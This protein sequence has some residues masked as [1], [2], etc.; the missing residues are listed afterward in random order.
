MIMHVSNF[1]SQ[2]KEHGQ[3]KDKL[4]SETVSEDKQNQTE[5]CSAEKRL[6][7]ITYA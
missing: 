1:T 7:K 4:E 5:S 2:V 6:W 3:F